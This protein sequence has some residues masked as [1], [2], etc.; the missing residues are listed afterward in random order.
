[1]HKLLQTESLITQGEDDLGRALE[2]VNKLPSL[3]ATA[4]EQARR[5]LLET[6]FVRFVVDGREVVNVE[7]RAPVSWLSALGQSR[8][9]LGFRS[10]SLP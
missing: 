2:L 1:M 4:D 10:Q 9:E 7:L 8:A 6:V 3:W 5:E